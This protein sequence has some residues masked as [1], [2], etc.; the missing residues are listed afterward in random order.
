MTQKEFTQR[1]LIVVTII[2]AVV[3]LTALVLQ[4][5]TIIMLTFASWVLAVAIEV[6][7]RALQWRGLKRIPAVI[8]TLIG[9]IAGLVLLFTLLAAPFVEQT[10]A[11]VVELPN[12]AE[13]AIMLYEDFHQSN[14]LAQR[15]LPRFTLAEY[16]ALVGQIDAPAVELP[17]EEGG[18]INLE[19]LISTIAPTIQDV[20]QFLGSAVA[21][22]LLVTFVTLFLIFDPTILYTIVV[23]LV[24][25]DS[26]ERAVGVMNAVYG[27]VTNWLGAFGLST[28]ITTV[29]MFIALGP[30]LRLPNAVALAIIAGI[31]T[32][33]PTVGPTIALIPVIILTAAYAPQRLLPTVILY[34]AIGATQ[35]RVIT[36]TIMNNQLKIPAVAVILF[37]LISA[38]FFGVL[39][40]LL[41]VPLVAILVTLVRELLVFDALDKRGALPRVVQDTRGQ[42]TLIHD[43]AEE[44]QPGPEAEDDGEKGETEDEGAS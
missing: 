28:L 39:G 18:S 22:L 30:I 41:A 6:P 4:L 34:A 43:E 16:Q 17:N 2:V 26:E 3:G 8:I 40:L 21:G 36:P 25:K 33:V 11:I 35:D 42:L 31:G 9:G 23:S 7:I 5:R 15:F 24:R 27:E 44:K 1:V 37:Q 14:N 20:G 13:E 29:L 12:A 10:R 32:L 38:Y 19:G